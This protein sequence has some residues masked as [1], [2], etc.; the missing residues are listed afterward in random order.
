VVF[1]PFFVC[2]ENMK[3]KVV[4]T[5]LFIDGKKYRRGDVVELSDKSAIAQGTRVEPVVEPVKRRGRPKKV[6][7]NED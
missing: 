1:H 5:T 7:I 6:E 4:M 3:Y 2:G